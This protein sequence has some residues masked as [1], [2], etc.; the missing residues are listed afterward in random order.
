MTEPNIKI[1]SF[2]RIYE[3]LL[4][5]FLDYRFK[6]FYMSFESSNIC[7]GVTNVQKKLFTAVIFGKD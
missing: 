2:T 6:F 1:A 7:K 3:K 4:P 5:Y